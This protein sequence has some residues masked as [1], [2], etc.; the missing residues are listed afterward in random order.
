VRRFLFFTEN[1]E[2]MKSTKKRTLFP[3]AV[4]SLVLL[5]G[6][7]G[8]SKGKVTGKVTYGGETVPVGTV[9]FI[10]VQEGKQPLVIEIKD[11]Q[12]TAEKLSPGT[13][14]ITVSTISQ[15]QTYNNL[16]KGKASGPLNPSG[17]GGKG[18]GQAPGIESKTKDKAQDKFEM[19]GLKDIEAGKE[20]TLK[21]LEGMIDVPPKYADPEKS[22]LRL[23]VKS[24]QQEFDID[25]PKG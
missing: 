12:Y 25:I 23:D 7:I 4:L 19:P 8:C 24:G 2:R 16:K 15:R 22:G 14:T 21:K 5:F 1:E 6:V 3:L 13:Y 18:G 10:P 17:G 9:T 11:G 20:E